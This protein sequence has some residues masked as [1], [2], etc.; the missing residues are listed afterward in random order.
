MNMNS[1]YNVQ[2]LHEASKK[3]TVIFSHGKESGP[4]GDKIVAL[5]DVAKGQGYTVES[6]DYRGIDTPDERVK[7]LLNIASEIRKLISSS[8][9]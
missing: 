4:N 5:A 1:D 6:P 8:S 3:P 7:H 9:V 2:E